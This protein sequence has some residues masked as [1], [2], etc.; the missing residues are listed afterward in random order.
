MAFNVRAA[1]LRAINSL[2]KY[3]SIPTYHALDPSNGSLLDETV[4]FDGPVFLTEKID[5]TNGRIISLPDGTYLIGSRE[6]LLYAQGDLIENPALG[7]VSTLSP[8][9]DRMPAPNG[10]RIVVRYLEVYGGKASAA[11]KHYSRTKQV[12][13]RLFDM[14]V[15]DD[16]APQLD[17]PSE[18]IAAWRDNGGQRFLSE[19]ELVES[20][21]IN[22]LATVPRLDKVD[23]DALPTGIPEMRDFLA[24]YLPATTV[25]LD[26]EPGLAEGIVLRDD[27]RR[28]IAKA[29]FQDYDRTMKRRRGGR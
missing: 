27:G 22:G 13:A 11:S 25:A 17:W 8:I 24:S 26:G 28:A 6:E 20:A 5:G 1:N 19:Y 16:Y 23:P 29:R 10:D 7:I 3:P 9:A 15:I 4:T 2:T 21:A 14:V 12:G 18:R